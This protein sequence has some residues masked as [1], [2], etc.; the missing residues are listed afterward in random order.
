MRE[1]L[2]E[3]CLDLLA[4]RLND[5]DSRTV[6]FLHGP[7]GAGKT[8]L[9]AECARRLG[10]TGPAAPLR[11]YA[12]FRRRTPLHPFL[13]SLDAGFLSEVPALL[14][15]VERG[16]W[17]DLGGI[18]TGIASP[19]GVGA[20]PDRIVTD[21]FLAYR[22]LARAW[23]RRAA[24]ALVPAILVCEDVESWHP[25]AREAAMTLIDDL[26][27]EPSVI[28]VV[29][30]T[31]EALPAELAELETAA[32]PVQPLGR[33]EIRSFARALFPG[34]E[35]PEA[36]V[37]R[38]RKRSGGLPVPVMS[39]LRYLECSGRIRAEGELRVG[40]GAGRRGEPARRPALR[41]LAPDPVAGRRLVPAPSRAL[42]RGGAARPAGP[43][44]L[45]RGRRDS[46]GGRPAN[47]SLRCSP[48]DSWPRRNASY[49][50]TRACAAGSR[51]CW[52]RKRL[53]SRTGSRITSSG[54][55]SAAPT[56]G[57]CFSSRSSPGPGGLATRCGC[58]PAS[59]DARSTNATWPGCAPSPTRP[60]SSSRSH[61]MPP[62]APCS[63][64][65]ARPG[66][67]AR[68][69]SRSGSRRPGSLVRDL[70]RL[71]RGEPGARPRSGSRARG[72]AVLPRGR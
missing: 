1:T 52:A 68:P 67:C 30:S 22:L 57:R 2:V 10:C 3:R 24:R 17:E 19:R 50:G 20:V 7:E 44:R 39:F 58:C 55:G 31:L 6:L 9:L 45:P 16:V 62:A 48:R 70:A 37:R 21:F 71:G 13:N 32:L 33:R 47:C 25:E 15:G 40:S 46:I 14:T 36:V 56:T 42:P 34:L 53:G 28:V 72:S 66:A 35:L 29:T 8:A 5:G 4:R 18:L 26:L 65:C 43:A 27:A 61:R 64:S 23:A 69:S 41:L 59:F 12:L 60:G 54:S 38:I 63:V 51:S 49:P 11:A